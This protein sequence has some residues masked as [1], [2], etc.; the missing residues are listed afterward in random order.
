MKIV[1]K[2]RYGN[3]V[4]LVKLNPNKWIWRVDSDGPW[5]SFA[6]GPDGYTMVDPPGGPC[7]IVGNFLLNTNEKITKIKY[8][9]Y[10]VDGNGFEYFD[11]IVY[12]ES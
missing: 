6:G 7:L 1:S 3:D 9:P 12:T 11:Y 5:W 2:N 4:T 8:E 10:F